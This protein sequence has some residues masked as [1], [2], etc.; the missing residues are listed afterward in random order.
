MFFATAFTLHDDM[1]HIYT[2]VQNISLTN[3]SLTYSLNSIQL[4]IQVVLVV[5]G[6]LKLPTKNTR[7]SDKLQQLKICICMFLYSP[8]CSNPH[9]HNHMGLKIHEVQILEMIIKY[10]YKSI[11]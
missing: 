6:T 11:L 5:T 2:I 4:V 9:N 3:V 8:M 10:N 1:V 7:A